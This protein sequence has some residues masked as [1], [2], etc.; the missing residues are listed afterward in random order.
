MLKDRIEECINDAA[1]F[2]LNTFNATLKQRIQQDGEDSVGKKIGPYSKRWEA[3][4]DNLPSPRQTGYVDLTIEGDLMGSLIVGEV[5]GFLA[6][7]FDEEE[8]YLKAIGQHDNYDTQIFKISD[9]EFE[10]L[11]ED[12]RKTYNECL[13]KSTVK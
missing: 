10:L 4:R 11:K 1:F 2:A 6:I 12:F 13:S 3:Y 9:D 5:N 7:G 8:Q